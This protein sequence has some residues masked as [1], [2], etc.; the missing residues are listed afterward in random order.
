MKEQSKSI[1]VNTGISVCKQKQNKTIFYKELTHAW[2]NSSPLIHKQKNAL[3]LLRSQMRTV[4]PVAAYKTD[5]DGLSAIWLIWHSPCANVIV[6]VVALA[7]VS[8]DTTCPDELEEG[9]NK[10]KN[11]INEEEK[12]K[13]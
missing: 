3:H 13:K 7:H 2:M 8:P 5:P 6:R 9:N 10:N 4:F 12:E 11:Q 1:I